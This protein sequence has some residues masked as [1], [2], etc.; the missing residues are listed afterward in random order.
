MKAWL[1]RF[2]EGQMNEKLDNKFF[3]SYVPNDLP[4]H[5]RDGLM[6]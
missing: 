5:K 6:A 4:W 3:P 1:H 2:K